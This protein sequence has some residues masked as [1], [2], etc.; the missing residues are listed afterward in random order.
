LP[1]VR[2]GVRNAKSTSDADACSVETEAAIQVMLDG[3]K[4]TLL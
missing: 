3:W 1:L 4:L 2:C